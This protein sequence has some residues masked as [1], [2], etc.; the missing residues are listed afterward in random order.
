MSPTTQELIDIKVVLV[1]IEKLLL[2]SQERRAKEITAGEAMALDFKKFTAEV[3]T[4]RQETRDSAIASASRARTP[5][6]PKDAS[7]QV[8]TAAWLASASAEE[9]RP[10]APACPGVSQSAPKGLIARLK[11]LPSFLRAK[12]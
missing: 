7:A 1:R 12:R 5:A 2:A 9:K 3:S 11:A 6:T 4:L 8:P 10:A